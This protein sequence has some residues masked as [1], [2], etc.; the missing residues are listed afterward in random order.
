MKKIIYGLIPLLFIPFGMKEFSKEKPLE[1]NKN[2]INEKFIPSTSLRLDNHFSEYE[3]YFYKEKEFWKNAFT[4]DSS[5]SL[6]FKRKTM[7]ILDTIDTPLNQK[8]EEAVMDSIYNFYKEKKKE[9]TIWLIRGRKQKMKRAVVRAF[10]HLDYIIDSL[11]AHSL[12]TS[13]AVIPFFESEFEN[14][15]YSKVGAVGMWQ[16]MKGTARDYGLKVHGRID[17]RQDSKKSL[18]AFIKYIKKAREKFDSDLLALVSY[19]VGFYSNYF[20]EKNSKSD[21]EIVKNMGFA[22]SQY[23]PSFLASLEILK[24]PSKYYNL[25]FK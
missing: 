3:K 13:L 9:K 11:E 18:S 21:V 17:E 24:D 5:K 16:F 6:I 23:F 15:A 10:N 8:K 19:N 20:S 2:S 7:E 25:R 1:K 22:P 14:K 12:P 4:L